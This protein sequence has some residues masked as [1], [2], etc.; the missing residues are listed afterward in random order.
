[1]KLDPEIIKMLEMLYGF[2]FVKSLPKDEPT[3]IYAPPE[4]L[5]RLSYTLQNLQERAPFLSAYAHHSYSSQAEINSASRQSGLVTFNGTLRPSYMAKVLPSDQADRE[6]FE[7]FLAPFMSTYNTG[8]QLQYDTIKIAKDWLDL[9]SNPE[10]RSIHDVDYYK[11]LYGS[12]STAKSITAY[13]TETLGESIWQIGY[14]KGVKGIQTDLNNADELLSGNSILLPSQSELDQFEK[15]AK[16]DYH[17]LTA[18]EKV[19]YKTLSNMGSD[20]TVFERSVGTDGFASYRM[21]SYA[22]ADVSVDN[23]KRG[24]EKLQDLVNQSA[25]D[26]TFEFSGYT[27][28][29]DQREFLDII[30]D[31]IYGSDIVYGHNIERF[32][33]P[34]LVHNVSK[35]DGAWEY[36]EKYYGIT[37]ESFGKKTSFDMNDVI[38]ALPE[39]NRQA[40][41]DTLYGYSSPILSTPGRTSFQLSSLEDLLGLRGSY[42][43]YKDGTGVSHAA[44]FD[45]EMS[46]S[47]LKNENFMSALQK[48]LNESTGV[49]GDTINNRRI[50]VNDILYFD[51]GSFGYFDPKAIRLIQEE[52]S[53]NGFLFD[54]GYGYHSEELI[55]AG[56]GKDYRVRNGATIPAKTTW[57][58]NVIEQIDV[59][60]L[61]AEKRKRLESIAPQLVDKHMTH[62]ELG[63]LN[64]EKIHIFGTPETISS[65]LSRTTR[66]LDMYADDFLHFMFQGNTKPLDRARR[67]LEQMSKYSQGV[68][69]NVYQTVD[70]L[71]DTFN[72]DV[73]LP[74]EKSKISKVLM[75]NASA[76]SFSVARGKTLSLEYQQALGLTDAQFAIFE[77][78]VNE[79]AKQLS[80]GTK[81]NVKQAASFAYAMNLSNIV[82]KMPEEFGGYLQSTIFPIMDDVDKILDARLSN[83][84]FL[85]G[86]VTDKTKAIASA[87]Q[88]Q[89]R[90]RLSGLLHQ[91]VSEEIA[92]RH[93]DAGLTTNFD[94]YILDTS[95]Q[96]DAT[97]RG[98][99][100]LVDIAKEDQHY[101]LVNQIVDFYNL[102]PNVIEHQPGRKA[103][104]LVRFILESDD[105]ALQSLKEEIT[106]TSEKG[107]TGEALD[108]FRRTQ[109]IVHS[110]ELDPNR[111][112]ALMME[113][114]RN[115]RKENPNAG[116]HAQNIIDLNLGL[117]NPELYTEI[118]QDQDFVAKLRQNMIAAAENA[119]VTSE[120]FTKRAMSVLSQDSDS[121]LNELNRLYGKD[122]SQAKQVY[123]LYETVQTELSETIQQMFKEASFGTQLKFDPKTN[124]FFL[125]DTSGKRSA[126]ITKYLP[127]IEM[128]AGVL[129]A[130]FGDTPYAIGMGFDHLDKFGLEDKFVFRSNVQR[131]FESAF[132]VRGRAKTSDEFDAVLG[133]LRDASRRFREDGAMQVIEGSLQEAKYN[134]STNFSNAYSGFVALSADEEFLSSL[135]PKD[136]AEFRKQFFER[137]ENAKDPEKFL[138]KLT[139]KKLD[140]AQQNIVNRIL[141][142][143]NDQMMWLHK[144]N[145]KDD[146]V[147]RLAEGRLWTDHMQNLFF[148]YKNHMVSEGIV[149]TNDLPVGQETFMR[150]ARDAHNQTTRTIQFSSLTEQEYRARG[151][152]DITVGNAVLTPIGDNWFNRRN[153]PNMDEF[154]SSTIQAPLFVGDNDA[155]EHRIETFVENLDKNTTKPIDELAGYS[156]EDIKKAS[157]QLVESVNVSEG[158]AIIDER[159]IAATGVSN[160]TYPIKIKDDLRL[161]GFEDMRRIK[162]V[163]DAEK[164]VP[165][166]RIS[167]DGFIS[168]EY[169]PGK[170]FKEG[171]TIFDRVDSYTGSKQAVYQKESGILRPAVF[172]RS[173][174]VVDA[175]I[176]E[177]D[178]MDYA[179]KH[180]LTVKTG[181]DVFDIIRTG[182]K[183]KYYLGYYNTRI[184]GQGVT[185]LVRDMSE[186]AETT[187]LYGKIGSLYPEV[188]K[189]LERLGLGAMTD[190]LSS[191]MFEEFTRKGFGHNDYFISLINRHIWEYNKQHKGTGKKMFFVDEQKKEHYK[192]RDHKDY[193]LWVRERIG[194]KQF[195]ELKDKL[196]KERYAMAKVLH[197]ATGGYGVDM[198]PFIHHGG[199]SHPVNQLITDMIAYKRAQGLETAEAN[200]KVFRALQPENN[201]SSAFLLRDKNG[202]PSTGALTFDQKTKRILLPTEQY[203]INLLGLQGAAEKIYGKELGR[204]RYTEILGGFTDPDNDQEGVEILKAT[205]DGPKEVALRSS[206][207]GYTVTSSVSFIQDHTRSGHMGGMNTPEVID[208][209][210]KAGNVSDREL[211]KLSIIRRSDESVKQAQELFTRLGRSDEEFR[212]IYGIGMK[213]DVTLASGKNMSIEQAYID[214][215][216]SNQFMSPE[217]I[218]RGK[219]VAMSNLSEEQLNALTPYQKR[220]YQALLDGGST[221]DKISLEAVQDV[222]Y[223]KLGIRATMANRTGGVSEADRKILTGDY[224]FIERNL[225]DIKNVRTAQL[226]ENT[227]E[228]IF[229]TNFLINMENKSIGITKDMIEKY[230]GV[231]TVATSAIS[232]RA[233]GTQEIQNEVHAAFSSLQN[234]M[235]HIKALLPSTNSTSSDLERLY[236]QYAAGT[237]RLAEAQQKV[238]TGKISPLKQYEHVG[239]AYSVRPKIG[240]ASEKTFYNRSWA[241]VAQIDGISISD[242]AKKGMVA[243]DVVRI[244]PETA[245]KMGLITAEKNSELWKIQMQDLQTNGI[246]AHTNRSPSSYLGSDVATRI[247]VGTDVQN[248][249]AQMSHWLAVKMKGDVDGDAARH[250]ANQ[251]TYKQNVLNDSQI[252]LLNQYR[253]NDQMFNKL[254]K[255]YNIK[256]IGVDDLDIINQKWGVLQKAHREAE[257]YHQTVM[258]PALE[259]AETSFKAITQNLKSNQSLSDAEMDTFR[260]NFAEKLIPDRVI[261]DNP[262]VLVGRKNITMMSSAQAAQVQK[263]YDDLLNNFKKDRDGDV[264]IKTF[265]RWAGQDKAREKIVSDYKQLQEN[266]RAVL[267]KTRQAVAGI[268]D[269]PAY[270][271]SRMLQLAKDQVSA[272]E[273]KELQNLFTIMQEGFLAPK[274]SKATD[275]S[276]VTD[277]IDITGRLGRSKNGMIDQGAFDD[278]ADWIMKNAAKAPNVRMIETPDGSKLDKKFYANLARTRLPELFRTTPNFFVDMSALE[279]VFLAKKGVSPDSLRTGLELASREDVAQNTMIGKLMN[280]VGQS[281][282]D[283][284]QTK[285][286]LKDRSNVVR[287]QASTRR[288]P[289]VQPFSLD[290]AA[291][292][293]SRHRTESAFQ[294]AA[295]GINKAGGSKKLIAGIVAGLGFAGYMGG[296]PSEDPNAERKLQQQR[297]PA[298]AQPMPNFSDTSI[299][300]QRGMSPKNGGYIININA[301]SKQGRDYA[302]QAINQAT[303]NAFDQMNVNITTHIKNQPF[304]S[305]P[306]MVAEYVQD[307]FNY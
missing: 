61:D 161:Q 89:L 303:S 298:N 57:E 239:M 287:P 129:S 294:K 213:D 70:E 19:I 23:A 56:Y 224:G 210:H 50:Q 203:D 34:K 48:E 219:T 274:N 169:G 143:L 71:Y 207:E 106:K 209:I 258:N 135:D 104:T 160:D 22:D 92:R 257:A 163:Q 5:T 77:N 265:E 132:S 215:I 208:G 151:M 49:P 32:D 47:L 291:R 144:K 192:I 88:K 83:G 260:Q 179:E 254:L 145:I 54:T 167:E 150:L 244:S 159:I 166:V 247:Y 158:G 222:T 272:D 68:L 297:Y 306:D 191:E 147:A 268:V 230:G 307:A 46:F 107:L 181:E 246:M 74:P 188:K 10:R 218:V 221:A 13:D 252:R 30:G 168:I 85:E 149:L 3:A 21:K 164:L 201:E 52:E 72:K 172:N 182:F 183:D 256:N 117:K 31:K 6:L 273:A 301:Q 41:Q 263:S 99:K 240:V 86:K 225:G 25:Q 229:N 216:R 9:P 200:E 44:D 214:E 277:L 223:G 280:A 206:R 53:G 205:D 29:S 253:D 15:I 103:D 193:E 266:R 248:D 237:K 281:L 96:G 304:T 119:E 195:E 138:E 112:A 126:N 288:G 130:R 125:Y 7:T 141:P 196:R 177:S 171:E 37:R 16:T 153:M 18:Q 78:K 170:Y 233:Y 176:V 84:D 127:R 140:A 217:A 109:A 116:L 79:I 292:S 290:E 98:K 69:K 269:L 65:A 62:I 80:F 108:S 241:D 73:S 204:Q 283:E 259:R 76:V 75:Q 180:G 270:R 282:T 146:D 51:K 296:N 115:Y 199:V 194:S 184:A 202:G 67:S 285:F 137:Y 154:S 91:Q 271:M 128:N 162:K 97:Q 40:L 212:A 261:T 157:Q 11:N 243:P 197:A 293:A 245:R 250:T 275:A 120:G 100:I 264:D 82:G 4:N 227:S 186:K 114:I 279:M 131:A 232:P 295:A 42:T 110:K 238:S 38:R 123:S 262:N 251:L 24:L 231:T 173:N 185:K 139:D 175:S 189:T 174:K 299:M 220:V 43:K 305:S 63:N 124:Q 255:T 111:I 228:N 27:L 242:Y 235:S 178:V 81:D 60:K 236:Q 190:D 59:T 133:Y 113:R 12:L 121:V 156:V 87:K 94:K 267:G 66:T 142:D 286:Q 198:D 39:K 148:D 211:T 36:L 278:L 152:N 45:S 155:L 136:A 1:M 187:E 101:N 289:R 234:T 95:G 276:A 58:V 28:R 2:G 105:P 165:I 93:P 118:A 20:D 26:K 302:Q 226:V 249:Q 300:A 102:D 17:S 55:Q 64:E 90:K 284:D 122:S 14:A 134:F 33:M 8:E 35:I